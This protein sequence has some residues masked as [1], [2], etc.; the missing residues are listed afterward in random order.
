[1]KSGSVGGAF[2]VGALGATRV[3]G[4]RAARDRDDFA[5]SEMI[6]A[7]RADH[8][9]SS[10]CA[11]DAMYQGHRRSRF[12][13][14][15]RVTP[16]HH[17]D[18][19]GIEFESLARQPIFD[20]TAVTFAARAIEDAVAHQVAQPRAQDVARNSGALLKLVEAVASE[21]R[22]AQYQHRPAL[23]D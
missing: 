23:A 8:V 21:K 5:R 22:L 16:S 1:M 9:G 12:V 15:P 7:M 6:S 13:A 2:A 3:C 20:A 19:H 10:L 18:Q 4:G 14:E 17:R 11:T